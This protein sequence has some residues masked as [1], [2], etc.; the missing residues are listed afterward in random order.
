MLKIMRIAQL[1]NEPDINTPVNHALLM[2]DT[3]S[4]ASAA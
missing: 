4:M 2:K 3:L 1:E